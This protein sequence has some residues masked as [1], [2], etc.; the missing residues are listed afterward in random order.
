[1]SCEPFIPF[2]EFAMG[3]EMKEKLTFER[4]DVLPVVA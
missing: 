3:V 2:F 4:W 1:M